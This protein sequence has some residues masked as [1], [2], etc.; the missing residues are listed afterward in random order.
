MVVPVVEEEIVAV[1]GREQEQEV[2]CWCRLESQPASNK[3]RERERERERESE[4][5][6]VA[7]VQVIKYKCTKKISSVEREG[8]VKNNKQMR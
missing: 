1:G 7:V 8:L 5:G 4:R 2:E 6:Q 3:E